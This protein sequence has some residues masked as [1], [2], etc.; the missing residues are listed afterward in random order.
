MRPFRFRLETVRRLRDHA[1]QRARDELAR[2][3]SVHASLEDEVQRSSGAVAKASA[4]AGT[5]DLRSRAS[6]QHFIERRERERSSAQTE[7]QQQ[8]ER[9]LEQ[10][11][12]LGQANREH[13]AI[14]RLE[15]KHR[16]RHQDDMRRRQDSELSDIALQIHRRAEAGAT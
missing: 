11:G 2:E 4:G 12:V 14:T 6:W 1:E 5:A 9:V 15:A 3:L 10:R 16:A 8:T 7:L 13:Q